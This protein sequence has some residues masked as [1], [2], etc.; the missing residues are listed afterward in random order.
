MP[1]DTLRR[2][3]RERRAALTPVE[4]A[5][6]SRAAIMHLQACPPVQRARQLACFMALPHEVQTQNF[7]ADCMAEGRRVCVPRQA[8]SGYAWSWISAT[9]Q[10]QPGALGIAEPAETAPV[11]VDG[12]DVVIVP[13]VAVDTTGNRLGHGGGHYDRLLADF[14]GPRI[15]LIFD[16]QRVPT[17]PA[18]AH[19]IPLTAVVT[20]SGYF[21][22]QDT[23]SKQQPKKENGAP[24]NGGP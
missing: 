21:P 18:A 4:V 5:E 16:F 3:I 1:K 20:E 11:E 8:G 22:L 6:R 13:A 24:V 9:T 10:W 19:D 23:L 14:A 7:V 2:K 12:L 15:G 17:V